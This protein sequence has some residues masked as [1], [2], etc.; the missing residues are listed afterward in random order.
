MYRTLALCLPA[1]A[2]SAC[3]AVPNAKR[4]QTGAVATGEPLAV[5]DDI[6][7]WTTTHKEKVGEAVTTDS[8]GNKV[9]TTK[10]YANRTRVHHMRVWYLAQG[11][12][13]IDDEDFFR[14]AGDKDALEITRDSRT[15]AEKRNRNGK[16][17]MGVGLAASLVAIFVKQPLARTGLALGGAAALGVG[18]YLSFSSA[19][20][21]QPEY[22][23]VSRS[24][25][26]RAAR[27]YNSNL[28]GAP[29][30]TVGVGY[31]GHF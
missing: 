27:K 18:W 20:Q 21:M 10:L 9:G 15:A 5:V 16:I 25:A 4:P 22:H 2:L 19:R 1:V 28:A 23:S 3:M 26:E 12:E 30:K 29:G 6:K 13:R 7:T 17:T 31:R 11:R 8:H 14:I 24:I